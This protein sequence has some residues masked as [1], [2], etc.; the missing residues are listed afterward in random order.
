FAIARMNSQG[1]TPRAP[2]SSKP[3]RIDL[4]PMLD[5]KARRLVRPPIEKGASGHIGQ[6]GGQENARILPYPPPGKS[7]GAKT[8]HLPYIQ[9]RIAKKT[10]Q[11]GAGERFLEPL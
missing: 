4:R 9:G 10:L 3:N 1:V 5:E 11:D 7:L 6:S 2:V 8:N